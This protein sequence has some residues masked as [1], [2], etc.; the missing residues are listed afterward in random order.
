MI[1]SNK[2]REEGIGVNVFGNGNAHLEL[3]RG[4]PTKL[5]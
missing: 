3:R 4:F 5:I 2:Y 1:I